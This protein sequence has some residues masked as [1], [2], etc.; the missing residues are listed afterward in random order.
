M[1][2]K[3]LAF[4]SVAAPV[5]APAS[6]GEPDSRPDIL[7]VLIDSIKASHVGC[8]GYCRDTTP[9]ID[10]FARE[11]CVRFETVIPGGS[12]TMPSV[13]TIFTSLPA[14]IHRRVLPSLPH[15]SEAVTLAEALR[16]SGYCTIGITANA[17]TNHRFGYGKGFDA[18]DDYSATLPPGS[19]I[20]KIASGYAKGFALTRMGLNRL[21]RR[22]PDKPLF[23]F[24]FY[25]DPH[26][27]FFPP[28][29]FDK[30][31]AGPGG[32]PIR[33]AWMLSAEKAT[34]E[35]RRR[36][37]DAYDGEIAYCDSAVSN[38]LTAVAATPRWNDTIVV[39]AGDHGESF[40]ERGF[41]SHGNDL[42]DQ[43]LKVPLMIRVP[44]S[45]GARPHVSVKGQ[46]GLV[47]L[48]PTILDL[49]G[50]EMPTGWKGRSLR[51][52]MASGKSDG[53]PV[54]SETRI[55]DRLWQR[56]VRTDR[57]KV[58]AIDDFER[59]CEAYDLLM[60]PCETNN[61]IRSGAPLP[62]EAQKL[63]QYLRPAAR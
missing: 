10:R 54:V 7:F 36:T 6:A 13:M 23:L 22:N 35:I 53:R 18:W 37:I 57:Y 11:E 19:A 9:F 31:F 15:N 20:E 46:V 44:K 61:L 12:W 41:S 25:M 38:L 52:A 50:V 59:P 21:R 2:W 60:D 28:P 42:Y 43:E 24:L 58:I 33:N 47:D 3:A 5:C 63:V 45:C 26:W 56:S 16:A 55:R 32:G 8:Y 40:W 27:D 4:L 49:A 62:P 14:D 17:M 39:I 51:P 29:P 34:P 30:K 48:A 1:N